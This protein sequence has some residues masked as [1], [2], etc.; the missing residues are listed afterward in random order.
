MRAP[1][2]S[3]FHAGT[4]CL[5]PHIHR[6]PMLKS[7]AKVL[8]P[9]ARKA[10]Q[11][12]LRLLQW[13]VPRRR[14]YRG[15]SEGVLLL[16]RVIRPAD[17]WFSP[18]SERSPGALCTSRQETLRGRRYSMPVPA[19]E[20]SG[21]FCTQMCAELFRPQPRLGSSAIADAA[22][23]FDDGLTCNSPRVVILVSAEGASLRLLFFSNPAASGRAGNRAV[24]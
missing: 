19:G 10:S 8:R 5:L 4:A 9:A 1:A 11:A 22:N 23:G 14:V 17:R 2:E 18:F 3:R 7:F 16:G 21:S 12:C 13:H 15:G 20:T 6:A 24:A